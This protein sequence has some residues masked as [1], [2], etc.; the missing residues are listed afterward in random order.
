MSQDNYTI[1]ANKPESYGRC[2]DSYWGDNIFAFELDSDDILDIVTRCM[3]TNLDLSEGE[4]GWEIVLLFEGHPIS[5]DERDAIFAMATPKAQ[6]R[7]DDY[8]AEQARI[9]EEK[10]RKQ[11][12]DKEQLQRAMYES[13][14][15]K[16]EPTGP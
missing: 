1:Y 16:F 10:K 7:L 6:K 3:V 2:G 14:K 4:K 15:K 9:A 5:Q 8:K 11:T 12:E 13:L